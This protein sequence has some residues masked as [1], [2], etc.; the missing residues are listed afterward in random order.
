MIEIVCGINDVRYGLNVIA[1]SVD[2][3]ICTGGNDGC[4]S[5]MVGSFDVCEV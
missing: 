1:G 5:V 2:V 3:L 4:L